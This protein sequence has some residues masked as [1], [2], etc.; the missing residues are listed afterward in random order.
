MNDV[1]QGMNDGGSENE[2]QPIGRLKFVTFLAITLVPVFLLLSVGWYWYSATYFPFLIGDELSHRAWELTYVER[3]QVLPVTGVRDGE[4]VAWSPHRS[5]GWIQTR[6]ELPGKTNI[7]EEGIQHFSPA[8]EPTHRIL[9]IGGSVAYGTDVTSLSATYFHRLGVELGNSNLICEIDVFAT[10]G[11]KSI[12]EIRALELYC[13]TH[14]NPDLI[15][16]IDGLNDLTNG[17]NAS[18]LHSQRTITKDGSEWTPLYHE[19]DY[20]ARVNR[21][22]QNMHLAWEFAT[23][24]DI[25]T[26]ILLQPALFEKNPKSLIESRLLTNSLLPHKSEDALRDSYASMRSGLELLAAR[27]NLWFL[28]GSRLFNGESA[29]TFVD[30]WHFSEFGHIIL[31]EALAPKVIDILKSRP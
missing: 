19:H 13:A 30:I 23:D 31:A 3:K 9:I 5:L 17:A 11:W 24:R 21:Y 1:S 14:A 12:Q 6:S 20:S 15:I 10:S 7:D 26:L 18:S 16:F 22:L 4:G 8:T 2:R 25:V 29:T 28:D 27:D